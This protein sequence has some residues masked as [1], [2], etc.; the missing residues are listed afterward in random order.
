MDDHLAFADYLMRTSPTLRRM[1]RNLL[2]TLPI[3]VLSLTSTFAVV[4]RSMGMFVFGIVAAVV[5]VLYW[6]VEYPRRILKATA[7]HLAEGTNMGRFG[8]HELELTQTGLTEINPTGSQSTRW[9]GIQM[10]DVTQ[11]YAFIL[12]TPTSG[13]VIPRKS[14]SNEIF[15]A[16]IAE[17]R[18]LAH[19]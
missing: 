16:F 14:I 4:T 13:Y 12:V 6:R 10:I 7:K 11:D 18:K 5:A 2:I 17:V 9:A 15:D 8:P 3:A 19:P 1:R